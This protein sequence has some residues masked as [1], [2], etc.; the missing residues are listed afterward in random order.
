VPELVEIGRTIKKARRRRGLSQEAAA[1]AV[2]VKRL[3]WIRW[4]HGHNAPSDENRP[5][6]AALLGCTEAALKYP[7]GQK[8]D[9]LTLLIRDIVER[10]VARA[11]KGTRQA[12]VA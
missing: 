3:Q 11:L 9:P 6:V 7:H 12:V 5:K 1:A 8:S 2:G 10:E 4:E